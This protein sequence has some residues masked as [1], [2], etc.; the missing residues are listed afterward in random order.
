V[1]CCFPVHFASAARCTRCPAP[2]ALCL[3]AC[4]RACMCQVDDVFYNRQ[5]YFFPEKQLNPHKSFQVRVRVHVCVCVCALS[6]ALL[7]VEHCGVPCSVLGP[8]S[9]CLCGCVWLCVCVW[10]GASPGRDRDFGQLLF[11][12]R[13]VRGRAHQREP[14]QLLQRRVPHAPLRPHDAGPSPCLPLRL[15]P[16]L[17]FLS[18]SIPLPLPRSLF[19]CV[20]C[21]GV[22]YPTPPPLRGCVCLSLTVCGCVN[23]C[24]T[25][26]D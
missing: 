11:Q 12:R 4:V 22:G 10:T 24:S 14:L 13:R 2:H 7:V 5:N 15:H 3:R 26:F 1:C 9:A 16:S 25:L 17:P 6:A 21:R 20:T 8:L 23:L 18:V 19:R